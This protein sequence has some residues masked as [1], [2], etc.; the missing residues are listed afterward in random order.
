VIPSPL[1]RWISE[2]EGPFEIATVLV[3]VREADWP[4]VQLSFEGTG[5]SRSLEVEVGGVS[6][7]VALGFDS[8]NLPRIRTG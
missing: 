4:Q 7:Q 2:V 6:R 1:C 8:A 5:D 3:S